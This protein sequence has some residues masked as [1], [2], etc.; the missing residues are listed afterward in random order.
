MLPIDGIKCYYVFFAIDQNFTVFYRC[1]TYLEYYYQITFTIL[2][3]SINLC[4]HTN[5]S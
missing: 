1:T 5:V 3:K 2:Q 4:D